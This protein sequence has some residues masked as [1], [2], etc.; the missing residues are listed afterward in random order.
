M[1]NADSAPVT[2]A[3]WCNA[4][5][6]FTSYCTFTTRLSVMLMFHRVPRIELCLWSI[7]CCTWRVLNYVCVRAC[8][9]LADC[10]PACLLACCHVLVHGLAINNAL[11]AMSKN[12]CCSAS[13]NGCSS[14]V[15]G[16]L[17]R[18]GCVGLQLRLW[19]R[20]PHPFGMFLHCGSCLSPT[21]F[22]GMPPNLPPPA[23]N[24]HPTKHTRCRVC[25][26]CYVLLTRS[27][28]DIVVHYSAAHHPVPFSV[29]CWREQQ[30]L[31]FLE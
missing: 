7:I 20:P 30:C 13:V 6:H 2:S 26:S 24:P 22:T 14:S 31:V 28:I 3:T 17:G 10:L 23:T 12:W 4:D 18:S 1:H 21:L 16:T 9:G 25:A 29:V 27:L 11:M 15:N 5:Q 19:S 8:L